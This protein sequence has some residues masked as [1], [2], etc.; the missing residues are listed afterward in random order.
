MWT[1][2]DCLEKTN[3]ATNYQLILDL[4]P[5]LMHNRLKFDE[6]SVK[7]VQPKVTQSLM[8]Y[9]LIKV[10]IVF[11]QGCISTLYRGGGA[12]HYCQ[13]CAQAAGHL[14]G[15]QYTAGKMQGFPEAALSCCSSLPS[16]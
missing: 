15:R 11:Q 4:L 2:Q 5:Q 14:L 8:A 10:G 7:T 13:P 16:L 1:T 6:I 9:K 12:S 3:L